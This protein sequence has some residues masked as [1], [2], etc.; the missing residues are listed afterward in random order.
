MDG[1][2]D[3]TNTTLYCQ[4]DVWKTVEEKKPPKDCS[5]S[6]PVYSTDNAEMT[7]TIS[8]MAQFS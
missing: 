1:E 2:E 8:L 4:D 3:V 6:A 5:K 7:F